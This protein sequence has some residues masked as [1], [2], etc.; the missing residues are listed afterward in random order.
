MPSKKDTSVGAATESSSVSVSRAFQLLELNNIFVS[1]EDAEERG[2]DVIQEAKGIV[3]SPRHSQLTDAQAETVRKTASKLSMDDELT[4]MV[5][6]WKL[7]IDIHRTVELKDEQDKVV[8]VETAWD[9]DNLKCNWSSPFAANVAPPLRFADP[10]MEALAGD[11]PKLKNPVPDLTY[12]YDKSMFTSEQMAINEYVKGELCR[13]NWHAFLIGEAKSIDLPFAIGVAQAA[14]AAATAIYLKRKLKLKEDAKPL[15]IAGSSTSESS[16][17]ESQHNAA[18]SATTLHHDTTSA[19]L[20][21]SGGVPGPNRGQRYYR[22]DKSSFIFTFVI[23]PEMARLFVAWAEEEWEGNNEERGINYHMNSVRSYYFG[24]GGEHWA[25]LH[26]DL[27]NVLD[28]G[29]GPRKTEVL[30]LLDDIANKK[31]DGKKRVRP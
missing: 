28:W 20:T 7:V 14:R 15:V 23:S 24:E 3:K 16:S 9:K 13:R 10:E 25:A 6:V 19:I 8:F 31:K 27:D 12:G 17:S 4:F 30:N 5:G 11:I 21:P 22:A 18:S 29:V 2:K 1:N 26:H